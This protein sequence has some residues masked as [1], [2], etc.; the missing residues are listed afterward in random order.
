[1]KDYYHTLG[2]ERDATPGQIKKAYRR[3][4][5][6]HHPDRNPDDPDAESRFKAVSE[7]YGVL[8]DPGK[9]ERYDAMQDGGAFAGFP[10]NVSSGESGFSVSFD[11]GDVFGARRRGANIETRVEVSLDEVLR[12]ASR[13]VSVPA[14]TPCGDC[15][16]TGAGDA[17]QKR[18]CNCCGGYGQVEKSHV[19]GRVVA[20][21][22]ACRGSG[23]QPGRGC[24]SCGGK[25]AMPTTKTVRVSI[26]PGISDGQTVRMRGEGHVGPGSPGDLHVR[27]RVRPHPAFERRGD[28]LRMVLRVPFTTVA[29][30]GKADVRTLDGTVSLSV[31]PGTQDGCVF[32][33]A[34]KGL[35]RLRA[36]GRGN[37]LVEMAVDVPTE[38][39]DGQRE[40]LQ[41]LR[42][43]GW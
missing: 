24:P 15:R 25:G 35:P 36:P 38:L 39:T 31:P 4:A 34:G 19:F 22:P 3:L 12:G 20:E 21:C 6:K 17:E 33:V 11:I 5:H 13:Q 29:L 16:G 28:D 41:R 18:P 32:K 2:V 8:S 1:M 40:L 10:F 27:V 23:R 37:M 43:A 42:E 14:T 7:A 30:G 9:R 26:P